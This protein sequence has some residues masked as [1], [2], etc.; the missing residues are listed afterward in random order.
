M[1]PIA[2]SATTARATTTWPSSPVVSERL[3]TLAATTAEGGAAVRLP[4][5]RFAPLLELFAHLPVPEAVRQ[6]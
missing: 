6:K 3:A 4:A 5:V 1:P 2:A